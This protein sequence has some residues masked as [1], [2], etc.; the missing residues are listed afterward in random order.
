M[1]YVSVPFEVKPDLFRSEAPLRSGAPDAVLHDLKRAEFSGP[2]RAD[3]IAQDSGTEVGLE[4]LAAE[5]GLAPASL[6]ELALQC[7]EDLALLHDGVLRGI[8]FAFPSGFRPAANLG[9]DFAAVHAPVADGEALRAASAGITA[10]MKRGH[11]ERGVWTLTSL[12]T[13][14]QHP[15]CT[16]PAIRTADELF[17]RTEFQVLKALGNGWTGFSVRVEMTPWPD[18][19]AAQQQHVLESLA[20]MSPASRSYK[21]LHEV[22]ALF[23]V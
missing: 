23:G 4:L 5:I 3:L 1:R 6:E 20:S 18:L 9:L 19:A 15:H 11:Y 22:A 12:G 14:S 8:A 16:R 21:N 10:A 13:L 7:R 2:L 17:F